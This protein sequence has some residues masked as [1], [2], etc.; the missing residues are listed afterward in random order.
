MMSASGTGVACLVCGSQERTTVAL[1]SAYVCGQ[2]LVES[3]ARPTCLGRCVNCAAVQNVFPLGADA[4]ICDECLG[5]SLEVL[6][7]PRLAA[8]QPGIEVLRRRIERYAMAHKELT[9]KEYST[10]A[11]IPFE[12]I[13]LSGNLGKIL[14]IC[15]TALARYESDE[16]R[17]IPREF[18]I[19]VLLQM[20][21]IVER[22]LFPTGLRRDG[23]MGRMP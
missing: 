8:S 10:T 22:L 7:G 11:E 13:M 20:L 12:E 17:G 18:E 23:R 15:R 3:R 16:Q 19:D 2:C 14:E 1:R 6:G 4:G 21:T 5:S 9:A